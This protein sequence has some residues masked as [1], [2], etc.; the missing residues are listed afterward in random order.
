M[1]YISVVFDVACW[2]RLSHVNLLFLEL[3]VV[4]FYPC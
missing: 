4:E 3:P 2:Q 1:F